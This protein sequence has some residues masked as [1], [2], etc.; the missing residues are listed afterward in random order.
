MSKQKA[1]VTVAIQVLVEVEQADEY[2]VMSQEAKEQ[3]R[4]RIVEGKGFLPFLMKSGM[5]YNNST[6]KELE[7]K[8]VI[9]PMLDW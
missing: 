7:N 6:I 1:V 2:I 9:H 3:L 5:V 4:K 8:I